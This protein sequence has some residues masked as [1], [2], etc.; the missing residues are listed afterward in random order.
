[1]KLNSKRT[2]L[3]GFAFLLISMFWSVYDGIVAKMLINTFGLDQF[4]SGV[5]LSIDNIIALFLLPIFGVISDKTR[6]RFG[7]RTPYIF[8]GTIV[9]AVFFVVISAIDFMQLTVV[10]EQG[11]GPIL[12][13]EVS[14]IYT[15]AGSIVEYATKEAAATARAH[16]ILQN[17]TKLNP[18][19]LAAFIGILL[20]V[21]VA[22]ASFRT[23]AVSLMPDVTTKPL[24]SKANAIIN[25]MGTVGGVISLVYMTFTAKDYQ[26]YIP[27]AILTSALMIMFLVLFLIS[28][29]EIKWAKEMHEQAIEY[30][31]EDKKSIEDL[32]AGKAEKMSPEV[33]RSFIFILASI[34][35]WFAGYNAAT[36][37]FSV[38]AGD[39][40][41]MGFTLPLLIAQGA[42]IISFIPIG[43]IATK[44]GRKKTIMAGISMITGA[45]ILGSFVT[46]DTSFLIWVTMALAGIGWATI[47]VNSYPMVVEMSRG[48]NI[49]KYTGYYYTASMSAQIFTPIL[50]GALMGAF[51]YWI[52]FPYCALFSALAFVTMLFVKHGDSKPVPTSKF[53]ALAG[54]DD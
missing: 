41:D 51:G 25:L 33:F 11:Y 43:I 52:L 39:V 42:A 24:R 44:V 40:L 7:K 21:L 3:V 9:A 49:G 19:Y 6:S 36:S 32:E 12:F 50:S 38:Y 22:M 2:I 26:S 31:I 29:K 48:S 46:R 13:N 10:N 18:G 20:I 23:P 1:M 53:E 27:T 37:K 14:N 5:V 17:V 35:L 30:G 34:V 47:N 4:W 8:I 15:F 45:F 28:V 54:A 16:L